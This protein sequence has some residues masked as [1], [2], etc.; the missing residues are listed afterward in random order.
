M[1]P[2]FK[3]FTEFITDFPCPFLS[4]YLTWKDKQRKKKLKNKKVKIIIRMG[5]RLKF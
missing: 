2:G 1:T 3:P 4:P 5:K